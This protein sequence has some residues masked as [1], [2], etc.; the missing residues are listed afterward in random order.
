MDCSF[1]DSKTE[2]DY[3]TSKAREPIKCSQ[4]ATEWGLGQSVGGACNVILSFM[5]KKSWLLRRCYQI[6]LMELSLFSYSMSVNLPSPWDY[7]L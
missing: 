5:F 1:D 2:L 4:M 3:E 7:N 6:F